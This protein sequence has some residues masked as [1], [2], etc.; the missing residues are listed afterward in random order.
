MNL[1]GGDEYKEVW[2]VQK[3]IQNLK[4]LGAQDMHLSQLVCIKEIILSDAHEHPGEH[5]NRPV[6]PELLAQ[7]GQHELSSPSF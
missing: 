3:W 2:V 5:H 1:E 4:Q 7:E 6:T